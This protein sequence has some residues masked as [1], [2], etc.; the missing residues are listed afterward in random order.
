[1]PSRIAPLQAQVQNYLSSINTN[2]TDS[3]GPL[4]MMKA[5]DI[6]RDMEGTRFE[7]EDGEVK[8]LKLLPALND[9]ELSQLE[10]QLPCPVPDDVRQLFTYCRGFEGVLES[11][12]FSGG[13]TAGFE[14]EEIFPHAIP[15]AHDG[16]GFSKIDEASQQYHKDGRAR[17]C[18]FD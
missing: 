14:M 17:S 3:L 8:E 10:S 5:I 11:I 2:F 18:D 6:L 7:D 13:L 16:N 15:I 12:D 9:E 1:M 4:K